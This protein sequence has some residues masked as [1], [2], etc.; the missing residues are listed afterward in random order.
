MQRYLHATCLKVVYKGTESV[1]MILN[2][3]AAGA[4]R[5]QIDIYKYRTHLRHSKDIRATDNQKSVPRT[6]IGGSINIFMQIWGKAHDFARYAV[7]IGRNK[8][9][10]F[11]PESS[12]R[13][14]DDGHKNFSILAILAKVIKVQKIVQIWHS[15]GHLGQ[16]WA[17]WD[18]FWHFS[19]LVP[20]RGREKTC[21]PSWIISKFSKPAGLQNTS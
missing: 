5:S 21:C 14:L 18:I 20:G 4:K 11:F 1:K 9:N 15:G 6:G 8:K 7:K 2:T 17:C 3:I 19:L 12:A 10:F 16:V 13:W